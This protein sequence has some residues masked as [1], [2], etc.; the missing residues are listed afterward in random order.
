MSDPLRPVGQLFGASD[1]P[2]GEWSSTRLVNA[3]GVRPGRA[4]ARLKTQFGLR[5][6]AGKILAAHSG[7][8]GGDPATVYFFHADTGVL[9][10]LT[11]YEEFRK[12][13][14]GA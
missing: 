1:P 13:D 6:I 3:T 2:D 4:I 14:P 9:R 10:P 5:E 12:L 11:D 7:N 8:G